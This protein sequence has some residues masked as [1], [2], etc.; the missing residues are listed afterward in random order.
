MDGENL[1]F[2]GPAGDEGDVPAVRREGRALVVADVVREGARA[3]GGK[4]KDTDDV[5]AAGPRRVGDLVE[6]RRRPRGAIAIRL[7]SDLLQRGA[8]GVDDVDL[9]AAG[10]VRGE[11]ELR[12]G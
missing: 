4:I 10:A 12:P 2:A 9:W 8:V 1:L 3:A 7:P 6:R 11:G 5:A